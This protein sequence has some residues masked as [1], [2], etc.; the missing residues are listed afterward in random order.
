MIAVR[1][2]DEMPIVVAASPDYLAR[3]GTPKTPRDLTGHDCIR[4]RLP[5]GAFFPWRFVINRRRLEVRVEGRLI[6]SESPTLAIRSAIEGAG[7]IQMPRAYV[8]ADIRA[9]RLVTVLDGCA[10]QPIDGFFLYYP[11]RRQTRPAL[12]ALVDFLRD[13]RRT[14]LRKAAGNS[15]GGS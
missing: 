14:H 1:V 7:L 11:S 9:G 3:R 2:S 15:G 4:H 6:V 8:A 12:N 10:P 5:S 13:E